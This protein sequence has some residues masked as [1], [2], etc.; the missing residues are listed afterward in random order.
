[1]N[2]RAASSPGNTS[3]RLANRS[4]DPGRQRTAAERVR[5]VLA[6]RLIAES[7]I[8]EG[9]YFV[10]GTVVAVMLWPVVPRNITIPWIGSVFLV[11]VVRVFLRRHY[12]RKLQELTG[13]PTPFRAIII[14]G[15]FAWGAGTL[16][17]GKDI[18]SLEIALIMV[19][20]AGLS[21]GA[22]ATLLADPPSFHGFFTAMLAPLAIRLAIDL[23]RPGFAVA[24][25]LLLMFGV[26]MTLSYRRLHRNYLAYLEAVEAS[27]ESAAAAL[28][29]RRFLDK[30]IASVPTAIAVLDEEQR[31]TH[32]NPAFTKL[33][34]FPVSEILGKRLDDFI[35]ATGEKSETLN[36]RQQVYEHGTLVVEGTRIRKDGQPIVVSI[37]ANRVETETEGTILVAYED[38]TDRRDREH[39]T[40]ALAEVS[41]ALNAAKTE[42]ELVPKVLR[43]VG[44]RLDWEIAALWRLDREHNSAR[45]DEV[46]VAADS[47]RAELADFIRGSRRSRR[48]GLIGRAWSE[49]RAVWL[50]GL[51]QAFDIQPEDAGDSI[52]QGTAAA[53][54]IEMGGEVI[55]VVSVYS[56]AERP[57][58][59][60]ALESMSAIATQLG[61]TLQRMR[62][63][64]TLR[65]TEA[66]Y[67][68]LVESSTDVAWRIDTSGR[69]T[70]LNNASAR[71]LG[72]T[73][74]QLRGKLF[75]S[76]SDQASIDRDRVALAHLL[77]G[78]ELWGYE[79]V[80]RNASGGKIHL[81]LSARPQRDEAGHITGAQG[82][83]HDISLEVYTRDALRVARETAEQADAAKSA[84]LANMSHEIRTPMTG[85]LG[86]AD[87]ILDSELTPEQRRSVD[88]IVAS[89]ET[90]LT[91]INDILDLSKIEAGQLE[92]ED[93]PFDL[94]E[95]LRDTVSLMG[96]AA[97]T[98]GVTL[99]LEM[100]SDV[101]RSVR[102][103]PTRIKQ[104]LNNLVSN[105]IKFTAK[106]GV[107]I[108]ASIT[109]READA[110][111]VRFAV[112][113]TGIGIEPAAAA[114][115]FEPFRQADASTTRNYGGTGLGLSISRRL[116]EM[117]GGTLDVDSI[118]GEGSEFHFTIGFVVVGN[119]GEMRAIKAV[120]PARRKELRILIAE[121]NPVNQ[122]VAGTMLR[123]RGHQVDI[124]GNGREAVEAVARQRYDVVLMDLQMPILD[125]LG[126]TAE[127]R[128]TEIGKRVPIIALTAN[129]AGGEREKVIAAGMDDYVAKPFRAIDLIQAVEANAAPDAP[130]LSGIM[131]AIA[132]APEDVDVDGLRAE[133][134]D[135]G[136]EDALGAVL[137]VFVGDAPTRVSVIIDAVASHD[138]DRIARA[139]HA[140]KSSAGTIRAM[141]LAGLLQ[142]LEATAKEGADIV[143]IIELRDRIMTTHDAVM[144]RLRAWI[145]ANQERTK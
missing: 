62:V 111:A 30:V 131:K 107:T 86:T 55:A 117:M 130:R 120:A 35:V 79:T 105:A 57:R 144:A 109:S 100:R 139:A 64:A 13:V 81:K 33:F 25:V 7:V 61:N 51:A 138:M 133:L 97:T 84:F 121:D 95:T 31:V 50:N 112:R 92:L 85:I 34:G 113:D 134:R 6:R 56:G 18:P 53:V 88:L 114:R 54:P 110:A 47:T 5:G 45:C 76:I 9:T 67:R 37:C 115:I 42:A 4:S 106:G 15:G 143:P 124:V 11:A 103:D 141:E 40:V 1:M 73:P 26:L 39:R 58:D 128:A 102:G 99:A 60:S 27:E 52:W 10:I 140:Y 14:T 93:I 32:V 125:G 38:I 118:P 68:Q 87:L 2:P 65:E 89:G 122:E 74:E 63:E 91:I 48:D 98:K 16:A 71:V 116:V 17:F 69:F 123:R 59:E 70:F 83:I 142:K 41:S 22:V 21:A 46:W 94:H 66:Q 75:T 12:E 77:S 49:R 19:V 23:H 90:L 101:P 44:Q 135:A 78:D 129:A 126:A 8:G 29:E 145:E 82:V 24:L 36:L 96:T 127:I 108:S 104:V 20:V 72:W 28:T 137:S 132:D 43:S 3:P 136:A 119:T 80:A